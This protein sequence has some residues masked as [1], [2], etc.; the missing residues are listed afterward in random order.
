LS[1]WDGKQFIDTDFNE[2][3]SNNKIAWIKSLIQ[4][5][6]SVYRFNP[7]KQLSEELNSTK[8]FTYKYNKYSNSLIHEE[9]FFE[10]K[11]NVYLNDKLENFIF[12]KETKLNIGSGILLDNDTYMFHIDQA[13]YFK[14][15]SRKLYNKRIQEKISGYSIL[16]N[17]SHLKNVNTSPINF[18]STINLQTKDTLRI[19][20][21]IKGSIRERLFD[22]EQLKAYYFTTIGLKEYDLSLLKRKTI[23]KTKSDNLPNKTYFRNTEFSNGIKDYKNNYWFTKF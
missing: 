6:D 18:K 2:V 7:N 9:V 19:I 1:C 4:I 23:N 20:E 14:N 22:E 12:D 15:N 16:K 5:N 13:I 8:V 11:L 3:I 10:N 21:K 17:I